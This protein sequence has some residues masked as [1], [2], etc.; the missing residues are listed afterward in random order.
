MSPGNGVCSV[1]DRGDVAVAV[2]GI[3]EVQVVAACVYLIRG[4]LGA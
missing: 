4:Q 1:A 3:R 2:V